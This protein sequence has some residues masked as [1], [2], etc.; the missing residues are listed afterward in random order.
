M[1]DVIEARYVKGY[2]IWLR[3]EDG[4]EG[5]VDLA[6]EL[7]GPVFEPLKDLAYFAQVQVN[8]D[9]GTIEWPN[10]ADFAPEFLYEK[11]RVVAGQRP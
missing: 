9:T 7:H 11:A 3:F 6:S 4:T 5:Q 2:T 10:R 8:S 1:L